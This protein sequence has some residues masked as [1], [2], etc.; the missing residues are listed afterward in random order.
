M[1]PP[2][3]FNGADTGFS[4]GVDATP[5]SRGAQEFGNAL[6]RMSL[7]AD[8]VKRKVEGSGKQVDRLADSFKRAQ[9]FGDN[10]RNQLL[11]V[12]GGAAA[13]LWVTNYAKAALEASTQ[14]ERLKNSLAVA[15]GSFAAANKELKYVIDL[16][17]KLG[18]DL[19]SV[20]F[21]YSSLAIAAR[22]TALAGQGVKEIF[23]GVS[24]ASVVLGMT[25]DQTGGALLAIQQMISKG[26]VSAEELRQQLGERLP[27]AFQLAAQAAG[28]TTAEFSK[29][30]A[31]GKILVEDLLP[32]LAALLKQ[33]YGSMAESA[34]QGMQ[35]LIN[36]AASVKREVQLAFAEGFAPK[37][38]EVLQ[39]QIEMQASME[40][41][42]RA[43]GKVAGA[44]VGAFADALRAVGPL[45]GG[46]SDMLGVLVELKGVIY[47]LI[48][49]RIAVWLDTLAASFAATSI[50]VE[51]MRL[52]LWK[53][54]GEAV[55]ASLAE[56]FALLGKAMTAFAAGPV[57]VVAAAGAAI[58]GIIDGFTNAIEAGNAKIQAQIDEMQRGVDLMNQIKAVIA[59]GNLDQVTAAQRKSLEELL[60]TTRD[61]LAQATAELEKWKKAASEPLIVPGMY[62]GGATVEMF[63]Q[64]AR[65]A[66]GHVEALQQKVRDLEAQL[67]KLGD[68]G[69][70]SFAKVSEA[71]RRAQEEMKELKGRLD[72]QL[73]V[74]RLIESQGLAG[75]EE[76]KRL[77]FVAKEVRG[78]KLDMSKLTPEQAAL[79]EE[80]K[81][82]AEKLYEA[83]KRTDKLRTTLRDAANAADDA[84][85]A[86]RKLLGET[87]T[88]LGKELNSV[89]EDI[90]TIRKAM[91]AGGF[92]TAELVAALDKVEARLRAT[93]QAQRDNQ[94]VIEMESAGRAANAA[95]TEIEAMRRAYEKV[96]AE[97]DKDILTMPIPGGADDIADAE[98]ERLK[99]LGETQQRWN[100][101][102]AAVRIYAD[103]IGQSNEK[104]AAQIH[105][106]LDIYDA[107]QAAAQVKRG[108]WS[109]G[110]VAGAQ[111]GGAIA[112]A[113]RQ[114]GFWKGDRGTGRYGGRLSG[115]Y[116]EEGA[117]V[118][119]IIGGIV[120][121]FGGMTAVGAA[122]GGIIGGLIGG[123]IKRGADEGIAQLQLIG[124]EI[125]V[126]LVRSEGGL[127][128][129][130][131]EVGR[132]IAG[133]VQKILDQLG[134]ALQ[135][136][137]FVD[138]KLRDD[139]FRV[140]VGAVRARF[141]E[142]DDAIRF[143]AAEI[144]KQS[145]ITGL[146][147]VIR[148]IL[149]RTT[150]DSLEGLA[151]DLDFGMWY[152]SLGV[153]EVAQQMKQALAEI[154]A[155]FRKAAEFG[156]DLGPIGEEFGRSL[157]AIRN[158]ILG[159][160]ESEEERIRRQAAAFNATVK[161]FEAEQTL[162][163]A[164]LVIREADL[165]AQVEA[166]KAEGGILNVQREL[167]RGR[168]ELRAEEV[169]GEAALL[170]AELSMV[171]A[172]FA[173]LAA[174]QAAIGAIDAILANLPA[175]ISDEE[176]ARAIAG[177]GGSG[178]G[179][180]AAQQAAA[181][182]DDI[183]E[184]LTK[185]WLEAQGRGWEA[186]IRDVDVWAADLREK[187]LAAEL[188]AEEL[189]AALALLAEVEADRRRAIF[190]D[191]LDAI[192]AGDAA[193]GLREIA[194]ALKYV[195]SVIASSGM[196]DIEGEGAANARALAGA[197]AFVL[198]ADALAGMTDDA[199]L[200]FEL[201]KIKWALERANLQSQLE[202]LRASGLLTAE[203]LAMLQAAFDSLP[204]PE[205]WARQQARQSALGDLAG[206]GSSTA[207]TILEFE[208][209]QK[210]L[211]WV[212]ANAALAGISLDQLAAM[213][214]EIGRSM[215]LSLADGL[216]RYIDNEEIRIQ[217]EQMR[218]ELEMANY[219]L[220][221][222]MLIALGL[223]TE[224]QIAFIRGLFDWIAAN[225]PQF[226]SGGAPATGGGG[227]GFGG[228]GGRDFGAAVDKFGVTV[229]ELMRFQKELLTGPNS[230]L[231][232]REKLAVAEAHYLQIMQRAMAGDV[233]AQREFQGA[234]TAYLEAARAVY[235][236]TQAYTDIFNQVL[237]AINRLAAVVA[238]VGGGGATGG[239]AGRFGGERDF[240]MQPGG[241]G[242]GAQYG[243]FG[244]W[245]GG[246]LGG[247]VIAG[248]WGTAARYAAD[249][250]N[251]TWAVVD[252]L[253]ALREE[254]KRADQEQ[255]AQQRTSSGG[256]GGGGV[257]WTPLVK[258]GRQAS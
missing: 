235:G 78:L 221:F 248:P 90:E 46:L 74:L 227:R 52:G 117:M 238:A 190:E 253:R 252:E 155:A 63:G 182:V 53:L 109:G 40:G 223:L 250:T 37:V 110:A 91:K 225:P 59:S 47:A 93:L 153:D 210:S 185:E 162:R 199:R 176:I 131:S 139:Q 113:G 101:I 114:Y 224:E 228:G 145:E 234:A 192:G 205:E 103:V 214:A 39:T 144:L 34:S 81:Q 239:A 242:F 226:G 65:D 222:E 8:G 51:A 132:S 56:K 218:F 104:L 193:K 61:S 198:V 11:A 240:G 251:A 1:S 119:A 89:G 179:P 171:Q 97:V 178:G 105:A 140:I 126:K 180:S 28:M 60:A 115:D 154:M 233:E 217:L 175:L 121:S 14:T 184:G 130:V 6:D 163:R 5:A 209:L 107:W 243:Q 15:S 181:Q 229:E 141:K 95:A 22:G 2:G 207:S 76:A 71:T 170:G 86:F 174:V 168:L 30:L 134:G 195:L 189:A 82:L 96:A 143:A 257:S 164:E 42:A 208:R 166:L 157:N 161:L 57:V 116:G 128:D 152:E 215:A 88:P 231:K 150:A 20:A 123:A 99:R 62:G 18:L 21:Q 196:A 165:K 10:F 149:E 36:R 183:L 41:L 25:A 142:M 197:K 219:R 156:L 129:V 87:D 66:Q 80:T 98:V 120:G 55:L 108:D 200:N 177:I 102:V 124:S 247:S 29:Q 158:S 151:A 241:P 204:S 26:V 58:A 169:R 213:E 220:Q 9:Q 32:K 73:G 137:P 48:A 23:E 186:A 159:I 136:M 35:A 77:S 49:I 3:N 147:D 31:Q 216:A 245:S 254:R 13:V 191:A 79:V 27:G 122:V 19:G 94:I 44:L 83:S 111:M 232:P 188:G 237:A 125:A 4:V 133:F 146:S 173:Q 211:E 244:D 33:T 187:L 201:S 92:S 206:L 138:I 230:P 68:A 127:G 75:D 16:S 160:S 50:A 135:S 194:D 84:R 17:R 258:R 202:F 70:D 12:G 69:T 249:Q 64:E 100:K 67:K 167:I 54:A 246:G 45:I 43:A 236:S 85:E 148:T 172:L 72:E 7:A 112:G 203:Q 38:R 212:R 256:G 24:Q 255:A 106:L 118:G